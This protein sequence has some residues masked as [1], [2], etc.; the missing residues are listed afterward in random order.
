MIHLNTIPP[1]LPPDKKIEV[2]A[3]EFYRI[4]NYY[5]LRAMQKTV[6]F[7]GNGD[8][9]EKKFWLDVF[10]DMLSEV[11]AEWEAKCRGGILQ[12]LAESL[13]KNLQR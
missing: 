1:H 12:N 8:S 10:C 6:D 7:D 13:K 5:L 9:F 2:A 3:K 4:F 11:L